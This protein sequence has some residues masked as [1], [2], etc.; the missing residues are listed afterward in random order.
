MLCVCGA[1]LVEFSKIKREIGKLPPLISK[2]PLYGLFLLGANTSTPVWAV[3]DQSKPD[4]KA[5]DV[6]YL[7]LN[8]DGDLT[9]SGERFVGIPEGV[10]GT[11]DTVCKFK[12]GRFVEPGTDRTHTDFTIAWRQKWVSFRMNW[13]GGKQTMGPY[14]PETGGYGNFSDSPQTAPIIVLGHDR[15]FQMTHWMSG[16]L[17]RNQENDFRVFIGNMGDRPGYFTAVDDKFLPPDDYVVG[18]LLYAD[19]KG[20]GQTIR[21]ELR[22]RC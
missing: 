13:L 4:A 1:E 20:A 19:K 15:P 7:D 18:T 12:I 2:Q 6:L 5:Y 21:F 16:T 9:Q 22:Q 17:R 10:S 14:A 8:G 3:L 11:G